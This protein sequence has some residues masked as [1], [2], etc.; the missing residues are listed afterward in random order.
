[1]SSG[2]RTPPVPEGDGVT[3]PLVD[4]SRSTTPTGRGIFADAARPVE[5]ELA[6]RIAAAVKWR[7]EYP[8]FVR[9]LTAAA[10]ASPAAARAVA[11]AGLASMRTRMVVERDG[12]DHRLSEG[13]DAPVRDRLATETI[14]GSTAPLAELRIPYRGEQLAG[15]ALVRQ[16]D[17]W[18]EHGIIEPSVAVA[19][20][21]V[22]DHP[23]WLRVD[24]RRIALIGA[25][26]EI[27]PLEPL[28][29]WGADVIAV[30]VPDAAV[31]DRIAAIARRG[32]GRVALPVNAD[33][34]S[35]VDVLRHLPELRAWLEDLTEGDDLVL[36]MYAYADGGRTCG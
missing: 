18:V 11:E 34:V 35:G 6:D 20:R 5:P 30:D 17:R 31:S 26:A 24:G 8:S 4:G 14:S 27:G 3:F 36:G 21:R 16:L 15:D 33:G 7:G 12:G 2:R 10:G 23:Q 32:A 29:A 28:T 25:A 9:E 1:M 19:V 13:L 22:I